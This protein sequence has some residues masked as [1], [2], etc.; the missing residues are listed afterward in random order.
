M[1]SKLKNNHLTIKKIKF[2]VKLAL[3][4]PPQVSKI[5]LWL[6]SSLKKKLVCTETFHP[7]S[8]NTLHLK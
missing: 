8:Y 3:P 6:F 1:L 2:C 5:Y 4:F 7:H